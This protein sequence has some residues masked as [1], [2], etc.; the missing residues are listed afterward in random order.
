[1]MRF[2]MPN[3]MLVLP[4]TFPAVGAGKRT[5]ACVNRL[6]LVEL[7]FSRKSFAALLAYEWHF[8]RVHPLVDDEIM[9]ACDTLSAVRAGVWP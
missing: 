6:V 8:P 1:M 4:K 7:P 9:S 3:Q 5:L 2:L